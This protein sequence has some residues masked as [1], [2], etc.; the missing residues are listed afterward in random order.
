MEASRRDYKASQDAFISEVEPI[1]FTVDEVISI[2]PVDSIG[3]M[4]KE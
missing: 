3:G 1:G 2:G 4:Q